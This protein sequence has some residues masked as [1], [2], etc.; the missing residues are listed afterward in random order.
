MVPMDKQNFKERVEQARDAV[1]LTKFQAP[2]A[3]APKI[4]MPDAEQ[5]WHL[6]QVTEEL[7]RKLRAL[8]VEK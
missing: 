4:E 3:S 2:P 1:G 5:I 7:I 8:T 6:L